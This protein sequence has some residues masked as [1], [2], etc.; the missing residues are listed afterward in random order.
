[1]KELRF[2]CCRQ[3]G[4]IITKLK[5]SGARVSCCGEVMIEL[6]ANTQDGAREKHLPHVSIAGDEVKAVV[7]EVI[8]PMTEAHYIEWIYLHTKNGGQFKYLNPGDEPQAMFRLIDDQVIA[9]YEYC[10]LHGLYKTM[11]KA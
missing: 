11:I 6:E 8:H 5:D 7:G 10:N 3:C 9:V 1:M 2:Y 4:N